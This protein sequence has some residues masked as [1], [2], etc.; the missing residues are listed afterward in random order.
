V[1]GGVWKVVETEVGGA[2]ISEAEERRK[3]MKEEGAKE[4]RKEEEEEKEKI[5]NGSKEDGRE[6]GNLE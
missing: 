4:R 2:R 5:K 6:M 3:E 1:S